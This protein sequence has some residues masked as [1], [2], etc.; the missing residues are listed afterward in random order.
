MGNILKQVEKVDKVMS[1]ATD[2]NEMSFEETNSKEFFILD[3]IENAVK[4]RLRQVEEDSDN[5]DNDIEW[6]ESLWRIKLSL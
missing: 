4:K 5:E 1:V 2:A 3:S 6:E